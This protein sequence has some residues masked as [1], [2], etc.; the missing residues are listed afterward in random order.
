M[1]LMN[2][3]RIIFD[4]TEVWA[5][6]IPLAF[7]LIYK[8]QKEWVPPVKWFLITAILLNTGIDFM[9]YINKM[10]WFG[11]D[12]E[13]DRYVNNNILYNFGAITRLFFFSWFFATQGKG[14]RH[15]SRIIP[16]VFII[17]LIIYFSFS[18]KSIFDFSS[19]VLATDSGL[20][21]IYCLWYTNKI[22]RDDKPA[23]SS[24]YPPF[25]VVGGLT[26]YTSVNFFIF[27]FFEYLSAY[28]SDFLIS[29]WDLHNILYFILCACISIAFY[30]E[31][32]VD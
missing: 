30:N 20:L 28:D 10:K 9:W 32:R 16:A 13:A 29:T 5:L 31:R 3:F 1:Q 23:F 8:P 14:F 17:S 24:R 19:F 2:I 4:W 7:L 21:L 26:L 22:M 12:P 15:I 18:R 6:L 11:Y 27:L 25:W